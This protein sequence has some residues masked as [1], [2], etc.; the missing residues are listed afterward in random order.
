M[1]IYDKTRQL[2][3]K[4]R[5]YFAD[6]DP[7]SQSYVFS[8]SH[9][10]MWELDYKEGWELKNWFFYPLSKKLFQVPFTVYQEIEIFFPLREFCKDQNKCKSIRAVSEE[11]EEQMSPSQTSCDRFCLVIKETWDLVLSWWKIMFS[12]D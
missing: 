7:S 1:L 4:Q 9:V 8:S 2:T 3:K 5:H 12:V 10:W 6:K 11:W